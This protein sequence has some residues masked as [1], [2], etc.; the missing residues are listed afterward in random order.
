MTSAT[1]GMSA[2]A[3]P[4]AISSCRAKRPRVPALVR[5]TAAEQAPML[6][7]SAKMFI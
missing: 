3:W 6:V 4:R 2:S 5:S 7:S 1:M